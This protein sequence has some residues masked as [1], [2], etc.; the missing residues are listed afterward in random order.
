MPESLRLLLLLFR[1]VINSN[2]RA[3]VG[4]TLRVQLTAGSKFFGFALG[5]RGALRLMRTTLID[6]QS[7]VV[8]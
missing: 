2:L 4:I 3:Q 6:K 5:V 1:I 7:V 8:L